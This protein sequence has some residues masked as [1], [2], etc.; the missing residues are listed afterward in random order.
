MTSS[1]PATWR[2]ALVLAVILLAGAA[3][4]LYPFVDDVGITGGD[5]WHA[6]RR[7]AVSILR[8]GLAMPVV[9][10]PY[11]RPGGFLY[12]Y[13]VAG[14]F[15]IFGENANAVYLVQAA[16]L[17][18]S[19]GAMVAALGPE[20]SPAARRAYLGTLSVFLVLDMFRHYTVRLLSENLLVAL[21][22]AC[23]GTARWAL[24]SGRM[25]AVLLAGTVLG[26]AVLARPNVLPVVLGVAALC[27][28]HPRG[29]PGGVARA[30]ALLAAA[31]AMIGL[32]ALRNH[33]VAGAWG[34]PAITDTGDWVAPP[35]SPDAGGGPAAVAAS[36]GRLAVHYG[37]R[38][39]FALGFAFLAD[40]AYRLRPHWIGMWALVGVFV[41]VATRR[42]AWTPVDALAATFVGLYL[43]PLIAAAWIENYGFRMVVPAV[44]V[45]LYLAVRGLDL[46]ARPVVQPRR[47]GV[48]D[49][50][51]A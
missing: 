38:L 46:L 12:S 31:G 5:D 20:L 29:R 30:T 3:V 50:R 33:A 36:V 2:S 39:A 16:L 15:A 37:V 14:L 34:V 7:Q 22:P 25:R 8:D 44:P 49:A 42:R 17:G 28:V 26:V 19:I 1:S 6:Y 21:L 18:L 27:L 11:R 47:A 43:G 4:R 35:A 40:P 51:S 41:A 23:L 24:E 32:M 48:D 10:G 9:A 45:A 13:F